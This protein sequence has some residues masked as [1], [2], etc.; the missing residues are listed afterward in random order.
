MSHR[1]YGG[2]PVKAASA[3]NIRVPVSFLPA[4]SALSE[5]V[6]R[7]P[8]I[9]QLS[10]G[11][12]QATAA[13][14]GDPVTL[15]HPGE[16]GWGVAGASLGAGALVGVG[17]TNGILIPLTP[18]NIASSADGSGLRYSVGIA[19]K[20]AAAADEFPVFVKPDQII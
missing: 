19:L 3:I 15:V 6:Y 1:T 2:I 13:S 8:S 16:V 4:A 7:T 10:I 9:N 14:P 11:L 5:T 12:A 18:S 20:N 17:S